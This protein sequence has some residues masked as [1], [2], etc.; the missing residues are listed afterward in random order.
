MLSTV[1]N[2][3]R[4]SEISTLTSNDSED[5]N[6]LR[7]D[8][9]LYPA[10]L[11]TNSHVHAEASKTL[12]G[13]NYFRFSFEQGNRSSAAAIF[14]HT[15]HLHLEVPAYYLRMMTRVHLI[16]N[17]GYPRGKTD[18]LKWF[19]AMELTVKET[20][21]T[22]QY[23]K[24]KELAVVIAFGF[25]LRRTY[26][27][28]R[29]NDFKRFA[30]D[31]NNVI[32][33]ISKLAGVERAIIQS[34]LSY[35]PSYH[36]NV[37][38]EAGGY[39]ITD[40]LTAA[41]TRARS[42]EEEKA[43][44]AGWM[45]MGYRCSAP[46]YEIMSNA[47]LI[48]MLVKRGIPIKRARAKKLYIDML[49]DA[50]A[51]DAVEKEQKDKVFLEVSAS[52]A[53]AMGVRVQEETEDLI[54]SMEEWNGFSDDEAGGL[55]ESDDEEEGLAVPDGG[56]KQHIITNIKSLYRHAKSVGMDRTEFEKIVLRELGV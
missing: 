43:R 34:I 21:E 55:I 20:A 44:L 49:R 37:S 28:R 33:P 9:K 13:K 18:P 15:I 47:E 7:K 32:M 2:V 46:N 56:V 10:I 8:G 38:L 1:T 23:N 40:S 27:R 17:C 11:R 29:G 14:K 31:C 42:A 45:T 52:S 30:Q 54:E 26:T 41:M 12:Y 39:D 24:F 3:G 6:E 50:D 48:S 16:F 53:G 25:W 5:D 19:K 4:S 22:L 51:K 36:P 35:D